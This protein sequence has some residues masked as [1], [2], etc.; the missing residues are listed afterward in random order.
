MV[1]LDIW[2]DYLKHSR[3]HNVYDDY[4]LADASR[5]PFRDKSFDII[6]AC[7]VIEHMPKSRGWS[8]LKELERVCCKKLS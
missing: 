8:F 2:K 4:V 1:G 3:R 7:E 6:L 5:L